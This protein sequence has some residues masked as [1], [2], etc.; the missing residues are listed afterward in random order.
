MGKL[1]R[2]SSLLA[3]SLVERFLRINLNSVLKSLNAQNFRQQKISDINIFELI[4][5]FF[6]S[7]SFG[8]NLALTETIFGLPLRPVLN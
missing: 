5:K 1:N 8:F 4:P 6:M 7:E 3:I 2:F